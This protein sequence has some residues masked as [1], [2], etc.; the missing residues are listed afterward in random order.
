[1]IAVV[2]QA[3]L[4]DLVIVADLEKGKAV[5]GVGGKTTRIG[6]R[7][8]TLVALAKDMVAWFL[9]DSGKRVGPNLSGG[10]RFALN[11]IQEERKQK[12]ISRRQAA[13]AAERALR[14]AA[15]QSEAER[16]QALR[17]VLLAR[18]HIKAYTAEGVC[19]LGI[20]VVGEQW[21]SLPHGR[22]YPG[23]VL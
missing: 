1:M 9:T 8:L 4:I 21:L 23:R 3:L 13:K 22:L 19:R 16:R 11:K 18:R 15:K 14:D 20:P 10:E 2:Y 5:T 12:E 7:D 6:G 17:A